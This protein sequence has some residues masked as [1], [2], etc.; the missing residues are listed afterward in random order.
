MACLQDGPWYAS[1]RELLNGRAWFH[2]L[3]LMR[4]KD[5]EVFA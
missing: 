3:I 2:S 1:Y 4:V 5:K